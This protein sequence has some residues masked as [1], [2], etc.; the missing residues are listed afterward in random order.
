MAFHRV[1]RD[2][3][4]EATMVDGVETS[5]ILEG[6]PNIVETMA[7]MVDTV[8]VAP[9]EGF[10]LLVISGGVTQTIG[11]VTVP[12]VPGLMFSTVIETMEVTVEEVDSSISGG[13]GYPNVGLLGSK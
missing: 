5:S 11:E 4:W 1:L 8:G 10:K 9:T 13:A 6:V 2:D 7:R 3:E 12:T